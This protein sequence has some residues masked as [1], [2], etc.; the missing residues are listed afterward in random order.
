[1]E[2]GYQ[3][4]LRAINFDF[5]YGYVD[6]IINQKQE[7]LKKLDRK[8]KFFVTCIAFNTIHKL[9]N[10]ILLL[11]P[12]QYFPVPC[13]FTPKAHASEVLHNH[14]IRSHLYFRILPPFNFLCASVERK[15]ANSN[16]KLAKPFCMRGG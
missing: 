9:H 13:D 1:M 15:H 4:I 2:H 10:I 3:W 7:T 12:V 16:Q 5:R 11:V 8:R 14:S 6:K